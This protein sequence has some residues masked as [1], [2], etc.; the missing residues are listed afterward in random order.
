MG[1]LCVANAFDVVYLI[2]GKYLL[3]NGTILF[4]EGPRGADFS[5]IGL[6]L[7]RRFA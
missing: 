7:P 6:S 5:L 4:L 1:R 2:K 3:R